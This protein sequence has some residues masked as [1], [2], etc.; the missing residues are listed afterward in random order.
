MTVKPIRAECVNC[1]EGLRCKSHKLERIQAF[2]K[3][4]G[5]RVTSVKFDKAARF[6][7]VFM[8]C[9]GDPACLK[10]DNVQNLRASLTERDR[11]LLS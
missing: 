7:P 10:S 1:K 4:S 5:F 9:C 3:L 11:G 8:G 6:N 2:G